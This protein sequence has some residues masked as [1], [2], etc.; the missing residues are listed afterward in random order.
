MRVTSNVDSHR[1]V[2]FLIFIC[3]NISTRLRSTS[4]CTRSSTS[5]RVVSRQVLARHEQR[6]SIRRYRVRAFPTPD[7]KEG[8]TNGRPFP[9]ITGTYGVRW[10][11]GTAHHNSSHARHGDYAA[12]ASLARTAQLS[13]SRSWIRS[14]VTSGDFGLWP[15]LAW[16]RHTS[17][18]M[19]AVP[20]RG[21]RCAV[22]HQAMRS[23]QRNGSAAT[24]HVRPSR[25]NDTGMPSS[26][27]PASTFSIAN[28]ATPSHRHPPAKLIDVQTEAWYLQTY[29]YP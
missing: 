26:V 9:A 19:R 27:T 22:S 2:T 11:P 12:T 18:S 6:N 1:L 5:E 24:R 28:N 17:I 16:T 10:V 3:T 21:I 8:P 29:E 25:T 23:Y 7:A 13:A 4:V 20:P 15:I 14:N